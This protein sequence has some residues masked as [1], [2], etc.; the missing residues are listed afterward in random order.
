[1]DLWCYLQII[2][3][4]FLETFLPV[5]SDW[6]TRETTYINSRLFG[7]EDCSYPTGLFAYG[8]FNLSVFGVLAYSFLVGVF[9][10]FIDR[11]GR[12][13][14]SLTPGAVFVYAYL[15]VNSAVILRTGAPRFYFYDPVKHFSSNICFDCTEISF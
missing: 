6:V 9:L 5:Y 15:I 4:V 2:F 3:I 12:S 14:V 11:V 10:N 8:L 1:M 13:I 7:C